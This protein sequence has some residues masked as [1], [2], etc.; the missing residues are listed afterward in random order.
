MKII[1]RS[2]LFVEY[3]LY[4]LIE[5]VWLYT[6]CI[7]QSKHKFYYRAMCAI[8]TVQIGCDSIPKIIYN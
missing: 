5:K 2:F 1:L 4:S 6:Q 7:L 8:T 3:Y